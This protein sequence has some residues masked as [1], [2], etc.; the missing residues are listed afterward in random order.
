M[1]LESSEESSVLSDSS[2]YGIDSKKALRAVEGALQELAQSHCTCDQEKELDSRVQWRQRREAVNIA[3][4]VDASCE[5]VSA[6]RYRMRQIRFQLALQQNLIEQDDIKNNIPNGPKPMQLHDDPS[7]HFQISVP[8]HFTRRDRQRHL[9]S[10]VTPWEG[11]QY[12]LSLLIS[13]SKKLLQKYCF[14][15]LRDQY[16]MIR[17]KR[18]IA[19]LMFSNK[20]KALLGNIFCAWKLSWLQVNNICRSDDN[21]SHANC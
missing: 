6:L 2:I 17:T 4:N 12:M 15:T 16:V 19:S 5:N 18:D 1:D 10:G 11:S 8:Q 9:S 21:F 14:L 7:R 20:C 3:E 13:L